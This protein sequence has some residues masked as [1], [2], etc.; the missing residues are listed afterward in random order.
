MAMSPNKSRVLV[1]DDDRMI[2]DT[3]TQILK[4]HGFDATP[5]YS[6]ESAL[7]WIEE[8]QPDIVLSD[9]V[10]HRVDGVEA[11]ARIR[12]LHPECRIILFSAS[13]LSPA[14]RRKISY[15]GFE[16][17]ERPLHPE[18]LL[19]RVIGSRPQIVDPLSSEQ[20]KAS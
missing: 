16:F 10:M 12:K 18:D 13:V 6:G 14:N 20:S 4:M 17:L 2:A 15:L 9:I 11:A 7:E 3:L 5:V 8:Y 19:A 1:I